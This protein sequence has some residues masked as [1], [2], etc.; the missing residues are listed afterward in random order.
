M[1]QLDNTSL[2]GVPLFSL[3]QRP[4]TQRKLFHNLVVED[5]VCDHLH[6]VAIFKAA[7]VH[8]DSN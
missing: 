6:L 3:G 7:L 1:I 8:Q 4:R 2:K 5:Q